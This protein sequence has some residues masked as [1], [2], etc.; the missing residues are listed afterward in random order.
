MPLINTTVWLAI[1]L[2]QGSD[3]NIVVSVLVG[4]G[5]GSWL[6]VRV[7]HLVQHHHYLVCGLASSIASLSVLAAIAIESLRLGLPP[8]FV[9]IVLLSLSF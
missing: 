6:A 7:A 8:S 3:Y 9:P 1:P 5:G 2:V 4:G